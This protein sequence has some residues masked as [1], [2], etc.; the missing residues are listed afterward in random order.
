MIVISIEDEGL[1]K[2][3]DRKLHINA[4]E[5]GET[6]PTEL[7]ILFDMLCAIDENSKVT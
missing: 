6:T 7:K 2:T 1:D 3:G 5:K 4:E